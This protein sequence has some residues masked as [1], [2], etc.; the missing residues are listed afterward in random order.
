M[1]FWGYFLC[2]G[3]R[4]KGAPLALMVNGT[5]WFCEAWKAQALDILSSG[6]CGALK[7]DSKPQML[8]AGFHVSYGGL[9][10]PETI[11]QA[12]I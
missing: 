2:I 6:V 4:A 3:W 12:L 5:Q 10:P 8:P 7:W 11:V 1:L 9:A